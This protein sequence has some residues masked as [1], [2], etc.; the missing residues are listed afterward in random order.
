MGEIRGAGIMRF[1]SL[2]EK[3]LAVLI[4]SVFVLS[5]KEGLAAS[6]TYYIATT[7]TDTGSCTSQAYPCLT[8]QYALGQMWSGAGINNTLIIA[9]GTYTG[10]SNIITSASGRTVPPSGSGVPTDPNGGYTVIKAQND[11]QV[12]FDGQ[13][14]NCMFN[15]QGGG[16]YQYWYFEGIKWGNVGTG[17]L[18]AVQTYGLNYV[19]FIRCGA[20][21]ATDN[22]NAEAWDLT[23][24]T[25]VLLEECYGWGSGRY[26]FVVYE[27]D[28]IIFR[29]CVGRNDKVAANGMPTAIFQDYCSQYVEFQNCIAI[30]SD[31]NFF[32]N[33]YTPQGVEGSFDTHPVLLGAYTNYGS[34][35]GNI[36]LNN[37]GNPMFLTSS[38]VE[39]ITYQ[40]NIGWHLATGVSGATNNDSPI[41]DHLTIG[42]LI[43]SNLTGAVWPADGLYNPGDTIA[44]KNSIIYGVQNSAPPDGYGI[45]GALSSNYNSFSNN[46]SGNYSEVAPGANDITTVN[47]ITTASLKYLPRIEAGS[48][49][50]TADSSGNSVGATVL[51]EYGVSGS[52]YGETDYNTLTT[53]PLWPFP[54]ESQIQTDF[55]S[56]NV[57]GADSTKPIGARGFAASGNGLYGASITLTSYIWEYLGNAMPA[58]YPPNRSGA[59]PVG[60]IAN[61]AQTTISL[62]TDENATCKY[63]TSSGTAYSAMTS[64]F[65]TTGATTHSQ[66]ITGLQ[67]GTTYT[68]YVRC[69]GDP[70]FASSSTDTTDYDIVFTVAAST[71]GSGS[72]STPSTTPPT[73]PQLASP[74]NGATGISTTPTL[75]FQP[76]TSPGNTVTYLLYIGTNQNFTNVNPIM[77][78]SANRSVRT[79][80]AKGFGFLAFAAIFGFVSMSKGLENKMR[81]LLIA[82]V[83][84]AS[85]TTASCGMFGHSSSNSNANSVTTTSSGEIS[86]QVT[87]TLNGS[88]TYYWKVVA[89][90][91]QGQQTSSPVWSFTTN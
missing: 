9:N 64:T 5:S 89:D 85:I 82:L 53:T 12:K 23:Y 61:T 20:W 15:I 71:G 4:F 2:K 55:A 21:D 80:Y 45:Y 33:Y 74:A 87:N 56:Y 69:Q 60:S 68:F 78:A 27:S 30:D 86:Y 46:V 44:L 22:A 52:L 18:P 50:A 10:P 7:G 39:N 24:S 17:T 54:Y 49:L 14:A 11:G 83:A 70:N 48:P 1:S 32:S 72:S 66:T 28:H 13:G 8:L 77:V 43:S 65:S 31:P 67:G 34:W 29:R 6:Y 3:L 37:P 51:Y 57:G 58:M 59:S 42:D 75:Q 47:P 63:S 16:P 73:V 41:Y 40:N 38:T 88:T 81:L 90:N 62:T 84:F 25:Y 76:S 19:K 26:K 79:Y 36:A 35:R 91:G